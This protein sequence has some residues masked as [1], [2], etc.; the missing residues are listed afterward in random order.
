M[1]KYLFRRKDL[2]RSVGT[3][4]L[5]R[6]AVR[7]RIAWSTTTRSFS[8]HRHCVTDA[9]VKKTLGV[10]ERRIANRG[11]ADT[12]LLGI[13]AER[14]LAKAGVTPERLSKL[15]VNKF[16]G[17][18]ILPMTGSMLQRRLGCST[19][20]QSFDIDGGITSFLHALDVA[21]SAI[22]SGDE[23]V[24]VVS[25]GISSPFLN[26]E[27]PRTAFLYGDG[28]GAVLLGVAEEPHIEASYFYT[29]YEYADLAVGFSMRQTVDSLRD[30][31]E[32]YAIQDVYRVGNWKDAQALSRRLRT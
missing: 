28:A 32:C 17:D 30:T 22:N 6:R 13:A 5:W 12:D 3:A 27:D 24:L 10:S 23:L 20:I 11:V 15:I 14:C 16:I 9:V 7:C 26:K 29:N 1:D 2:D 25:G 4:Q 21:A 19:A 31:S 8:E 18:R